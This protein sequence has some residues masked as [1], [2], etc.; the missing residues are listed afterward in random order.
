LQ[1]VGRD[2]RPGRAV[3][4]GT[5]LQVLERLG[6]ASLADLPPVLPLLDDAGSEAAQTSPDG[7]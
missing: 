6:L 4:Y 5:T 3:L 1:E 7:R 2:G